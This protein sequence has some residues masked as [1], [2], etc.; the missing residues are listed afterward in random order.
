MTAKRQKEKSS[1]NPYTHCERKKWQQKQN[2]CT[3]FCIF[4]FHPTNT[5]HTFFLKIK[6]TS[7]THY[8]QCK[9]LCMQDDFFSSSLSPLVIVFWC[10]PHGFWF[11]HAQSQWPILFLFFFVF[12]VIFL[13][14][15]ILDYYFLVRSDPSTH[16]SLLCSFFCCFFWL[17]RIKLRQSA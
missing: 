3:Y 12:L 2:R 16:S 6:C 8:V 15:V 10:A 17:F 11:A 13:L 14:S 9:L 7:H 1:I 5:R 4:S